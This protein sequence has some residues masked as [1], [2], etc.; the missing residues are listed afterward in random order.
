MSSLQESCASLNRSP[1]HLLPQR[2]ERVRFWNQFVDVH[3]QKS[4]SAIYDFHL[5]FVTGAADRDYKFFFSF[6]C[7][8]EKLPG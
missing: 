8:A 2:F 3:G 5:F 7:T 6:D 1:V 4:G